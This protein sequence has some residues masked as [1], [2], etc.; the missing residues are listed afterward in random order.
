[1][2]KIINEKYFRKFETLACQL[3]PENLSCD[4]EA[5]PRWVQQQYKAL[6]KEWAQV[7]KEMS[8]EA[9]YPKVQEITETDVYLYWKQGG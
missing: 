5:D 8:L 4:G 3:S 1:M 9:G 6:K 2:L 7:E